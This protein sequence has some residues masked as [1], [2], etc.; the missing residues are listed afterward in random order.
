MVMEDLTDNL[1]R[2]KCYMVVVQ[3]YDTCLHIGIY[4]S[5]DSAVKRWNE[6]RREMLERYIKYAEDGGYYDWHEHIY[7]SNADTIEEYEKRERE[8]DSRIESVFIEE[9]EL[10]D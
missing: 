9:F 7:V 4:R 1:V 3:S 5:R 8:I 2:T 6:V 10:L